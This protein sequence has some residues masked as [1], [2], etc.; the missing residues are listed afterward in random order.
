MSAIAL[1]A[2]ASC[3]KDDKSSTP[4]DLDEAIEDGFYVAGDATGAAALSVEYGM[5]AGINEAASQSK[6]E[7]M[8]EKYIYLKGG[9]DFELLLYQAGK[10]TRYSAELTSF[11]PEE[12][13]EIY[14]E[15]PQ[16]AI[17]KGE[18]K[19][20][21]SA[22]AMKVKADGLYHIVLDLNKANDLKYAQIVVAPVTFGVRGGMNSWGFTAFPEGKEEKGV[23]TWTL[24]EQKLAANGE[25][26]FAYG[27]AWKITL[28]D[29]GKVRANTNLGKDCAA[30][31]DNIKVE[32]G[33]EYTITLSYKLAA[34]DIA[35]SFSYDVTL[36]KESTAPTSMYMIGNEFGGWSWDGA[37]VEMVPVWGAEG[38]FWTT[39]YFHA[40]S[41][42][43]FKFCAEKAWNGDFGKDF[44]AD[45]CS[46]EKDGLYTVLIDYVNQTMSITDAQIFGMG[47]CFGSWD[48][49]K[50]PFTVNEDGTAQI[51][52]A[53][54][55]NLRIY[56]NIGDAGNW[57]HSEYNIFD[58]KIVYRGAGGD[59]DAVAV[60]AEKTVILDFNA[61]TGT[62]Q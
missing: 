26:K 22:P 51:T 30:G 3:S 48:E 50:Y 37:V 10:K 42:N 39:R 9:K 11:T 54:A 33:G 18:L 56:T 20:G 29:Q 35:K 52:T 13:S 14:G 53:A 23:T 17:F 61:G 21:D 32:K 16:M 59:Q 2:F 57:W 36:T 58:G 60:E 27:S 5:A 15:D 1:L 7:G 44:G 28:D 45:N 19:T 6:R 41:D 8:Y 62:I 31:G 4:T 38:C 46:V 25:F 49:G 55:G 47:D 34:G 12:G 24:T 43:G 40:G